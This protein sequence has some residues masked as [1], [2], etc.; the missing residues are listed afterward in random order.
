[1]ISDQT[2]IRALP[3]SSNEISA[4]VGGYRSFIGLFD[5]LGVRGHWRSATNTGVS[6][7]EAWARVLNA[8]N[9]TTNRFNSIVYD[10]YSVRCIKD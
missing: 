6:G 8:F 2:S 4:E 5:N 9:G 3:I 1:M 7:T 10:G